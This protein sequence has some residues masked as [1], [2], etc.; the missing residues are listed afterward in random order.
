MAAARHTQNAEVVTTLLKAGADIN[1]QSKR[2]NTALILAARY[3]Q[4]LEV[5]T[6]LL[7]A[8]ADTKVMNIDGKTAWDY[9]QDNE[10]VKGTDVLKRLQEASQ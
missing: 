1:A 8:G 7:T 5:I 9:A 2:G 4:T 3:N 10:A 6:T